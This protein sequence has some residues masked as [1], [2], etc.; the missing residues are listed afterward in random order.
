MKKIYVDI[1][2]ECPDDKPEKLLMCMLL[3][4]LK[5]NN[6]DKV[7]KKYIK[8]T[9][10]KDFLLIMFFK[11]QYYLQ[12]NYFGDETKKIIEPTA[13]CYIAAHNMS[14]LDKSRIIGAIEKHK[15]LPGKK[16]E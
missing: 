8:N 16:V 7:I 6:W 14:K 3:C 2:N 13:D 15:L 12:F 4:D 11:C 9:S 10:K 5:I 1:Y